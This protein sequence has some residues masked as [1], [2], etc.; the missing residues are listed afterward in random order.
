MRTTGILLAVSSLPCNQGI[1]DFGKQAH[2]FIETLA[3]SNCH[4][5][6]ILPLNPLGYGNSPYQPFSSFAGDE[7]YINIDRLA[8]YDLIKQSSVK[9]FNKFED[10]VDYEGVREF[11]APYFKKAYRE[12]KKKFSSFETEYVNFCSSSTWLDSYALFMTLKRRNGMTAWTLWDTEERELINNASANLGMYH[13]EMAYEKFLQFL[14]YKQWSEIK[15]YANEHH[16]EIMG[17]IPF[18]VGIDSADVWSHQSEFLLQ[19][20]GRPIYVAGVPPDYFSESGQRWGN[21]LYNWRVMKRNNYDFW[22]ERLRWNAA[23]YD[24]VRIDHF[25]AFD[26]YWKIPE[27][28]KTAELGEWELGPSYDLLDEIYRQLPTIKIIAEDLG[29]LRKEVI[30]LKDHYQLYGMQVLQFMFTAKQMKKPIK[31]NCILYTGTHDNDVTSAIYE[32]LEANKK[33]SLRRFFHLRGYHERNVTDLI[34]RYCLD[35]EADIVIIPMQDILS[36]KKGRMNTPSTIDPSNWIWKLKNLKAF[37]LK[38]AD[39]KDWIQ[40]SRRN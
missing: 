8:D 7:I 11:K 25:R 27:T 40:S 36:L 39:V 13:D 21:P 24:M 30:E 2:Y 22:I 17:D 32:A 28:S 10:Y 16:V 14:F 3:K 20:D 5:W 15:S 23:H 33:A 38:I 34:L 12:F 26:T 35:S 29:D 19:K 1:G 37:Q 4:I 9:T 6:Q 18:Y 31:K